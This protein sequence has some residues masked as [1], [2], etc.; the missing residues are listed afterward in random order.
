MWWGP[1][2]SWAMGTYGVPAMA[3]P[4]YSLDRP[5][6]GRRLLAVRPA[7]I[8]QMPIQKEENAAQN[9]LGGAKSCIEDVKLFGR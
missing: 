1:P 2:H 7:Y 6:I 4:L 9:C 3:I 5:Y 8:G